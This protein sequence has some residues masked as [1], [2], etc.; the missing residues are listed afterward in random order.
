MFRRSA[1]LIAL[2]LLVVA[3]IPLACGGRL[4]VVQLKSFTAVDLATLGA[5]AACAALARALKQCLLL[6]RLGLHLGVTPSL[7]VSLATEAAFALTPAGAGGYAASVG[8]L[9]RVGTPLQAAVATTIADALLDGLFFALALPLAAAIVID[10]DAARNL[11][12][13]AWATAITGVIGAALVLLARY[14]MRYLTVRL[15]ARGG[16]HSP[17][18]GRRRR[19]LAIALHLTR[20]LRRLSQA[21]PRVLLTA[22]VLTAGQWC[23]RYAIFW[24]ILDR[25]GAPLPFALLF[26]LQALVLHLAQ[27]TGMPAGA[28]GAE[29]GLGLA[30]ASR[31]PVPTLAAALLLWRLGTLFLPACAGAIALLALIRP[32]TVVQALASDRD[33]P[34]RS[35]G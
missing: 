8:L 30:L 28:G 20:A 34:P 2:T 27:W 33:A 4:A 23:A 1:P 14:P 11:R 26:L 19:W 7:A 9:R 16:H 18:A 24:L 25:L 10:S 32:H 22:L 12:E 5:L 21:G 29:F 31:L 17:W 15:R 35:S 3:A 13:L 6:N